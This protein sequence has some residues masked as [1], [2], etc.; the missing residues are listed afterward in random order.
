GYWFGL[1]PW[2][3][4][5]GVLLGLS[6]A[7]KWSGIW[8]LAAFAVLSV[9]WDRGARRS[10]GSRWPTLTV[11]RRDLPGAAFSLVVAPAG[12]YLLAWSGWFLG[13]SS[14]DRH[15]AEANRG[16]GSWLP[17]PIRSLLHYHAEMWHFHSKLTTGHVYQ[18][19]PWSWLVTGR[20]VLFY[21][22]S[23]P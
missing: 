21:Y 3:T 4:A 6:C 9:L 23:K 7:V 8:F 22:P 1:R 18:S 12:A 2:R 13:E 11:A 19:T 14:Y 15:W 16:Y 5:G 10:A 17:G 20:P